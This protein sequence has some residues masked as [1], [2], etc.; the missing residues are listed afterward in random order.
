MV[1]VVFRKRKEPLKPPR[2]DFIDFI[3]GDKIQVLSVLGSRSF[4]EVLLAS[5]SGVRVA[6]KKMH[7]WCANTADFMKEVEAL[8]SLR[9]PNIVQFLGIT[10]Y[11]DLGLCSICEYMERGDLSHVL[12]N[13]QLSW[14]DRKQSIATDIGS[15]LVY[16]HQLEPPLMHRDLKSRNILIGQ[17]F[18][19]KL[20]DFGLTRTIST[21]TMTI[22]GS[23]L[24]LAPEIYRGESYCEK[25]DIYS[26]GIV[27][28][29]LDTGCLPFQDVKNEHGERLNPIA[30]AH[31]VAF[32][33]LRPTIQSKCPTHIANLI[34]DC[35]NPN[36]DQ[37]PSAQQVLERLC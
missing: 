4:G 36:P 28:S 35:T 16:L 30:I 2:S 26:F 29:E 13:V 10:E 33:S 25:A 15:G 5:Y 6:L 11:H 14:K 32:L 23:T 7:P 20:T 22:A 19:A 3:H 8:K 34:F 12:Q 24:W 31:R 21:E 17:S 18:T 1:L 37:R 9:H 27:L